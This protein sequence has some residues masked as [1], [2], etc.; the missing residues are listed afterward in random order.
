MDQA[1]LED[2]LCRARLKMWQAKHYR[3]E[4]VSDS[5]NKL[6][7]PVADLEKQLRFIEKTK[8]SEDDP[9]YRRLHQALYRDRDP[10]FRKVNCD[11]IDALTQDLDTWIEM[12]YA[13]ARVLPGAHETR[14]PGRRSQPRTDAYSV[15]ADYWKKSGRPVG[16]FGADGPKRNTLGEFIIDAM[17][18][19][20]PD[21]TD[22]LVESVRSWISED[23]MRG[24]AKR[25]PRLRT[26]P[27]E[28]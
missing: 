7:K 1:S 25:K 12:T 28:S 19:I 13:V 5:L 15:L 21:D 18:I 10:Y 20:A 26:Q 9:N 6:V 22:R 3:H 16:S 8:R 17:K 23:Y 24:R 14:P 4:D 11:S 2:V 27:E